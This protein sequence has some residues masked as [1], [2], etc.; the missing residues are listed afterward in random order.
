VGNRTDRLIRVVDGRI[1][2][3]RRIEGER[4]LAAAT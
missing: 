4:V 1:A 2:E 3:E